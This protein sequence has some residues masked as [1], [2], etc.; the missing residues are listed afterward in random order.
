MEI[1]KFG[2]PAFIEDFPP[3]SPEY[4]NLSHRWTINVNGWIQQATPDPAYYF[5]NPLDTDIPSGTEAVLVEWVAFPGRLDQYYSETPPVSPPNPYNLLQTQVYELADTGYYD[6]GRKTFENIPATLCPQADWSG[7]LKTFGPYG[8]RG[9]LD[10]YCEWSTVR[11]GDGNLIRV[12]FACENP[13][14]WNTMWKV[15]QERVRELYEQTLNHG[16]SVVNQIKV[17][18]DDLTLMDSSGNPVI[19]PDTGKRAYNPL[20]K[21]NSGPIATRG[22]ANP[23]GGVMHLT[24]T[25]NTLQTELG[26]AGAAT[27]Q[28]VPP[29]FQDD[30]ASR[31]SDSQAL[32]CCGNY[33]QAY[34]H[35]DPTIGQTVN[36][37]VGGQYA[38]MPLRACLANPVGLYIQVPDSS[39]FAFGPNIKAG[40]DVPGDAKPI[41]IY[42]ILRGSAEVNDPVSGAPFR[43][44]MVLHAAVQIPGSWLAMNPNLTLADML[45]NGQ[46]I[47]WGGQ[48][49]NQFKIGLFARPLSADRAAPLADC[50]SSTPTPGAPL[51]CVWAVLWDA[52]SEVTEPCPT[53]AKMP[54]TSNSTFIAPWL[55]ADGSAQNLVLTGNPTSEPVSVQV[56]LADGSGPDLSIAVTLHS[57]T[58]TF[59]A[60]PGNSYPGNYTALAVTVTVPSGATTGLRGI[61]ITQTTSNTV[62][63]LPAAVYITD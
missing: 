7:A 49:A 22:G 26:L 57:A 19:D 28:Y 48:I 60:V 59:Y 23:Y 12:D 27:V 63:A 55:P 43:G 10:E 13:E 61:Q 44:N 53:G 50:S 32:I 18:L 9:W 52:M 3:N 36:Q 1:I 51:Q 15:S 58:P 6:T 45:I 47:Q 21:W 41:D 37:V 4:A 54:L 39:R 29:Q 46:P 35:S 62:L 42:Q 34:R 5:Y 25:P 24:S 8:P 31:N 17:T 40:V 2:L 20:N 11:D 30:P 33:G 16:A 38:G 14:Y 56:Q